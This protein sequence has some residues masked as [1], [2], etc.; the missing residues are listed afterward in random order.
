MLLDI[1]YFRKKCFLSRHSN[2]KFETF[3]S[4]FF[5]TNVER[6]KF[7]QCFF[8]F[9][10]KQFYLINREFSIFKGQIFCGLKRILFN[11]TFIIYFKKIFIFFFLSFIIRVLLK[12]IHCESTTYLIFKR[13][14]KVTSHKNIKHSL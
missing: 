5:Q 9:S 14:K 8:Q 12:T 7:F 3:L 11:K 4:K 10:Q 2:M 1:Q 6:K 13:L